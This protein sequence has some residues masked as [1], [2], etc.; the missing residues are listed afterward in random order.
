[1][2][3]EFKGDGLV[4]QVNLS[5]VGESVCGLPTWV[6]EFCDF[7]LVLHFSLLCF[8][9]EAITQMPS[10]REKSQERKIL[11]IFALFLTVATTIPPFP[12]K[13]KMSQVFSFSLTKLRILSLI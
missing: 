12:S 5:S 6:E 13:T 10:W 9:R 7:L 2:S 4:V 1:M 11:E 3:R 8:I